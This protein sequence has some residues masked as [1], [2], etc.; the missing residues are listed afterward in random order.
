MDEFLAGVD[1]AELVDILEVVYAIRDLKKID[2]EHL[3]RLRKKK[4]EKRGGFKRRMGNHRILIFAK[5]RG[6]AERR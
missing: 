5:R 3:E 2:R 6:L 4:V 1:K